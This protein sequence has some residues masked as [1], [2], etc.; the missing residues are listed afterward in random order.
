MPTQTDLN[1]NEIKAEAWRLMRKGRVLPL[2]MT[3]LM[4]AVLLGINLV[5][6]AISDLLGKTLGVLSFSFSF[7]DILIVLI[8]GVLNTGFLLYCLRIRRGEQAP[9][10][11]LFDAFAFAGK[12]VL[13]DVLQWSLVGF[14]FS[15]FVVPGVYLFFAY[16]MASFHLV[17]EPQISVLEALRRSRVEMTG[18]KMQLIRLELSFWPLLLAEMAVFLFCQSVIAPALPNGMT[19]DLLYILI[20]SIFLGI[21]EL[22]LSPYLR[23]ALAGFYDRVRM[24]AE[25]SDD[26]VL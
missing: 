1:L 17:D 10:D 20:S 18:R 3:A 15:L 11:S 12:V 23:L 4:L 2:R 21:V 7:F 26:L 25:P 6:T 5:G 9:Y 13:L 8:S 24:D 19:G 14:G 22:F 16:A